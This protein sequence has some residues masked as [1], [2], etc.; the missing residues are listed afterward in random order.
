M[1]RGDMIS[2]PVENAETYQFGTQ[3]GD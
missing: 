1:G 3:D 2:L